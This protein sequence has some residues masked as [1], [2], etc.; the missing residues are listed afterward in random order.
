MN[1]EA[2]VAPERDRASPRIALG[3]A[4]ARKSVFVSRLGTVDG[5]SWS[6]ESL[7]KS[8]S[9]GSDFSVDER[10]AEMGGTDGVGE[11]VATGG[12]VVCIAREENV[13][14]DPDDLRESPRPV[15]T[16]TEVAVEVDV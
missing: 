5:V 4:R 13:D 15:D 9:R 2:R 3:G 16:A 7:M 10:R 1:E 8:E 14:K 11:A 6:R 12:E